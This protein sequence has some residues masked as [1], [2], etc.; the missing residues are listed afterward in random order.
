MTAAKPIVEGNPCTQSLLI[1]VFITSEKY[2]NTWTCVGSNIWAPE[3]GQVDTGNESSPMSSQKSGITNRHS[4]ISSSLAPHPRSSTVH[5]AF[6]LAWIQ[7]SPLGPCAYCPGWDEQG[8]QKPKASALAATECLSFPKR[9][10]PSDSWSA[11]LLGLQRSPSHRSNTKSISKE[12]MLPTVFYWTFLCSFSSTSQKANET[13]QQNQLLLPG[14]TLPV[15][16]WPSHRPPTLHTCSAGLS[17][18]PFHQHL[19]VPSMSH[20]T[21]SWMN[22]RMLHLVSCHSG[23][24]YFKMPPSFF[25]YYHYT[26]TS[27]TAL[28][29]LLFFNSCF[30]FPFHLIQNTT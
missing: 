3:P 23:K 4:K 27:Q 26:N 14:L 24:F 5:R 21:S 6:A 29:S 1:P 2:P 30:S 8:F 12:L 18:A 15:V 11:L 10:N 9:Q 22:T 7:R 25:F 20:R 16:A 28:T 17:S 13:V 19:T